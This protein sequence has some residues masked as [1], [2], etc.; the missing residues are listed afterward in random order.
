MW[1]TLLCV[2]VLYQVHTECGLD[3]GSVFCIMTSPPFFSLQT[4]NSG[5]VYPLLGWN[6]GLRLH[7]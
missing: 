2:N 7:P 5:G 6:A 3:G 1:Q 4:D